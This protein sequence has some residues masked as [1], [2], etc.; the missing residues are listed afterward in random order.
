MNKCTD[1]TILPDGGVFSN[2]KEIQI[3]QIFIDSPSGHHVLSG[4]IDANWILKQD[5]IIKL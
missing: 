3:P 5:N 4:Y 2:E 1:A